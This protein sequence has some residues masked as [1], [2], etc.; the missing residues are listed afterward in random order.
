MLQVHQVRNVHYKSNE[1]ARYPQ[2]CQ[3]KNGK[4]LP[5]I[6]P[7]TEEVSSDNT[8]EDHLHSS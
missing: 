8:H 3:M 2:S 6:F 5:K 4:T 7:D 1:K